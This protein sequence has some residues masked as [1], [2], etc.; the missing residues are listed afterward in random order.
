MPNHV[1]RLGEGT[2]LSLWGHFAGSITSVWHSQADFCYIPGIDSE[3]CLA[4]KKT[5]AG[6][7]SVSARLNYL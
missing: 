5:L 3:L 7:N 6:K 1:Q 4:W 2:S